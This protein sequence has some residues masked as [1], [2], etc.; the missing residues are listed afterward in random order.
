MN[1]WECISKVKSEIEAIEMEKAKG[2]QIRSRIKYI[3]EGEKNTQ[4]FLN[5]EKGRG[6][7]NTITKL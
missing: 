1:K 2:A 4:F 7:Y 3:E 5:L 6:K